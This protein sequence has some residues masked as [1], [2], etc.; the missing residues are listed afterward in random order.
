M[1]FPV[2]GLPGQPVP[3]EAA[4]IPAGDLR[5]AAAAEY[6]ELRAPEPVPPSYPFPPGTPERVPADFAQERDQAFANQLTPEEV[7]EFRALRKEKKERDE[8]AA[9]AVAEAAAKLSPP[10]H[11]V[12]LADGSL[13]EGSTIETHWAAEGGDLIPVTGAWLKAEYV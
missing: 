3:P 8:A 6:P 9:K 7:A 5:P 11:H 10:T 13:T 1:S 12:H 4:R 2:P